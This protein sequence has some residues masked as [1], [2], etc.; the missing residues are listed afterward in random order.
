MEQFFK[1]FLILHI[2]GGGLGLLAGTYNMFAK[3]GDK[4]HQNIGKIFTYSMLT[5]AIS[6]LILATMHN[7]PFLLTV[8]VFTI[9]L[10]GTAW[11]YLSLKK[12]ADG[13]NPLWIDWALVGFM[14][15]FSLIFIYMGVMTLINGSNFGIVPII[16]ALVG[17]RFSMNDYNNF[18]G[19]VKMK[20]YWL[21]EHLQRMIGAYIASVTA[22]I[23]VNAPS[24][25][26]VIPW[27]AP[28]LIIV[29]FIIIWGRKYR[30]K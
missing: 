18:Q 10:T 8:G 3:K 24:A 19:K 21:I 11:R 1:V 25:W 26:G 16:F 6:A 28:T 9:Y 17:I 4:I 15:I 29:P 5:S 23:V 14:L 30:V 20:N 7:N 2:I 22:F 13:Q 27:I 12:L